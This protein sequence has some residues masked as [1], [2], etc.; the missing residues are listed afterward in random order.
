MPNAVKVAISL[1]PTIF[2]SVERERRKRQVSRSE[3]FRQ[4]VQAFLR[5]LQERADIER[6]V[7]GYLEHPETAEEVA[8]TSAV[9]DAVL[10]EEPWD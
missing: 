8:G 10:A 5:G 9:S 4:A 6:Y 2:E 3:F 7:R 1:P